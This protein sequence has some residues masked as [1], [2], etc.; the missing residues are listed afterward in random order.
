MTQHETPSTAAAPTATPHTPEAAGKRI[1]EV[2]LVVHAGVPPDRYAILRFS[3]RQDVTELVRAGVPAAF[4]MF[5]AVHE[6]GL[7][8]ARYLDVLRDMRDAVAGLLEIA[9]EAHLDQGA[10]P[11][12][13]ANSIAMS[14]AEKTLC[15][16]KAG[17][18]ASEAT[19]AVAQA[20]SAPR[21]VQE[22]GSPS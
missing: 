7:N 14:N 4:E 5:D 22:G 3:R 10:S 6:E 16:I 12:A 21:A 20:L 19:L 9:R 17:I 8:T 2:F 18:A 11:R 1:D 13:I 15:A